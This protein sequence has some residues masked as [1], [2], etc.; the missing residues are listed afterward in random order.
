MLLFDSRYSMTVRSQNQRCPHI[1]KLWMQLAGDIPG[2]YYL[3]LDEMKYLQCILLLLD[4]WDTRHDRHQCDVF[5]FSGAELLGLVER[6]SSRQKK[7]LSKWRLLFVGQF[8]VCIVNSIRQYKTDKCTVQISKSARCAKEG[9][10]GGRPFE[11]A[12]ALAVAVQ[13]SDAF[14]LDV[15]C[16]WYVVMV[17]C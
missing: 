6:R 2:K 7:I 14:T 17:Q 10:A 9:G 4:V 12:I 3:H 11:I 8:A 16:T 15:V 13:H 5:T 1:I